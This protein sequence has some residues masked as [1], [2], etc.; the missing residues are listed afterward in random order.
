M[1]A[2]CFSRAVVLGACFAL[3]APAFA[4]NGIYLTGYGSKSRSMGGVGIGYTQDAIGSQLNPAGITAVG[5]NAMRVDLDMIYFNPRS[6]STIPDP[7]DPP[8]AGL[9]IEYDSHADQ[10][11]IPA[12]GAIYKFNRKLYL[13]FSFVGAGGG[14]TR[15]TRLSPLGFNFLNPAGRTDVGETLGVDYLQAQ[16]AITGAYKLNK[17]HT[18]AAAPVFGVARFRSFGLGVFK[19]FSADPDNLTNRGND[20][21]YGAGVRFGWQ[22]RLHD[23]LTVGV[24]YTSKIYFTK[25]DKYKG[26]FAEEGSLDNPENVGAGLA[27]KLTDKIDI[28]FDWT[29]VYYSNVRSIANPIENLAVASGFLGEDDGAGFGW[30]DQD[31]YKVGVKYKHNDKWDFMV[32]YNYGEVP[33]PDDQLL[34]SSVAPAVTEQHVSAG[35]TYRPGPSMEWTFVYVHAFHNKEKGLANSGGQFDQFFPNPDLTGPGDMALEMEQDSLGVSF[36]YKL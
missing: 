27:L 29:R 12:M 25:F 10:Y 19:P 36:S 3:S 23:R 9:P 31:V 11:L 21:A 18:V 28:A 26:L 17:Y 8:N 32:G 34:F 7:R 22:G 14:G 15:Y 5:V 30:E 24:A 13:G 20:Y 4:T 16:M 33:M 35:L 2:K 6:T 1:T